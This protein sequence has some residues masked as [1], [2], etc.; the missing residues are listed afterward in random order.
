[1]LFVAYQF[2]SDYKKSL[3][4]MFRVLKPGG[5]VGIST[6]KKKEGKPGVI[7][8]VAPKYLTNNTQIQ[9]RAPSQV[10]R[11]DFGD[12]QFLQAILNDAGFN[13][14]NVIN[15]RRMFYYQDCE[16]WWNEQWSHAGRATFEMIDSQ[17]NGQLERFRKEVF[18]ELEKEYGT[19]GIPYDANVLVAIAKK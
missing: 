10:I 7:G 11:P 5:K 17:G 12:E 15:E 18:E 2:F 16:E 19:E 6:W 1:M 13:N 14:I 4:E 3:E 8:R 9:N